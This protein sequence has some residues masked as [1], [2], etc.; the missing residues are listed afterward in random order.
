MTPVFLMSFAQTG[1]M[2]HGGTPGMS[3]YILW[4]VPLGVPFL[5]ELFAHGP[6][7]AQGRHGR[8]RH[9]VSDDQHVH[10]SSEAS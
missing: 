9:R 7:R 8:R 2:H 10:L 3:R 5:R 6:R 4:L 1:N